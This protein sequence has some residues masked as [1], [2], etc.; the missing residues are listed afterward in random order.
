MLGLYRD[1]TSDVVFQ[2]NGTNGADVLRSDNFDI[3]FDAGTRL[4]V[5]RS[6]GDWYRLEGTYFGEFGWGDTMAVRNLDAITRPA[7]PGAGNLYSPFSGFGSPQ[8]IAGVDFNTFATVGYESSFSNA[9]INLRRRVR[10][11]SPHRLSHASIHNEGEPYL[12]QERAELSLLLGI[13]YVSLD[14]SLTYL[15]QSDLPAGGTV[16]SIQLTTT[17]ELIGPQVGFMSQF[18]ATPRTWVD[19]EGKAGIYANDIE[20]RSSF[21]RT[22]SAAAPI[23]S[24]D[25]TDEGNHTSFLGEL[26]M[27]C[28]HQFT[29][30]LTLRAGYNAVWLTDVALATQNFNNDINLTASGPVQLQHRGNT[31]IHGPSLGIVFGF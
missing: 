14:D 6:L 20:L 23:G 25:G 7:Q 13:R 15:T 27:H 22:N 4:V 17:N 2:R 30:R 5:G 11:R 8:G 19:L 1:E 18:L 9:E 24:F 29:P 12:F 26:M 21:L 28:N 16:N 3:D 31:I 10:M